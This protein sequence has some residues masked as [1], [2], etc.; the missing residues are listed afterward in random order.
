MLPAI[1]RAGGGRFRLGELAALFREV[2]MPAQVEPSTREGYYRSWKGV[3]T[4]LLAYD[5]ADQ[6]LP[7][8]L[9]TLEGLTMEMLIAGASV[10]TIKNVWCAI[11]DRHRMFGH[12]PPLW[13]P[14]A[15]RRRLKA[16]ASIQGAPTRLV[17]PIGVHHVQ[18]MLR[19]IGLTPKERR[20]V[21]LVV[22]GT[23][24]CARVSE[25]TRVQTCD[26][27][28]GVD[29]CFDAQYEEGIG[30]KI[31][32]GKTDTG[33]RGLMTRVPPSTLQRRMREYAIEQGLHVHPRCTKSNHPGAKCPFLPTVLPKGPSA[34]AAF[35]TNR[36][37]EYASGDDPTKRNGRGQVRDGYAGR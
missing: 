7:M 17:F 32:K 18:A 19:L 37:A 16:L 8:P 36:R 28:W 1:E 33:R 35:C 9:E 34:G 5:A 29:A 22:S 13:A 23:V 27:H 21:I 12:R 15:F 31:R 3:V 4:W 14:G 24:M 11:E 25:P 26:V 10:N 20:N 6:G 30:I 2:V